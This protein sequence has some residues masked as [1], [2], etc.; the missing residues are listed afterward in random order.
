VYASDM[1]ALR[2]GQLRAR[3]LSPRKTRGLVGR[4]DRSFLSFS[5]S[6]ARG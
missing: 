5:A 1:L 6:L 3:G 4:S 2:I